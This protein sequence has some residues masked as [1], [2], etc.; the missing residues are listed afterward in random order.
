MT[1]KVRKL[2][3]LASQNPPK[4]LPKRLRNRCP[5]KHAIFQRFLLE[6]CSFRCPRFLENHGFPIGKSLFLRFSLKSCFCNFR[7]CW[8]QK[9][10]QKPFQNETQTLEKSML[11]THWFLTSIFSRLGLDFGASWASKME[12]NWPKMAPR[13]EGAP[14]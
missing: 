2:R 3:I 8:V 14:S 6:F 7:A 10:Y 5:N 1:K 9:T 13:P 11:K 4:S 12:P